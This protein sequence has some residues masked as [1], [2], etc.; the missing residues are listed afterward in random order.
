ML[1]GAEFNEF[2]GSF[3]PDLRWIAYTSDESGRNEVYVRPFLASGP[4]GAPA[5]GEGKWQITRDGGVYS[6]WRADGKEIIYQDP[7]TANRTSIMAVD[8]K[9]DGRAFDAGIPKRLFQAP[10]TPG[11]DVSAD[12][13]RFLLAVPANG[14]ESASPPITVLLNWQAELKK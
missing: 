11:W 5:L 12:G 13:K 8:V 10:P 2:L 14:S 9:S 6:K 7:T 3:S 4:L 1:L